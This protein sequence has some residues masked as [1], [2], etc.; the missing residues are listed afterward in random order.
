MTPDGAKVLKRKSGMPVKIG[1]QIGAVEN[2]RHTGFR[3][4]FILSPV[5]G[6]E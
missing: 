5:E 4:E 3:R 6:P 2:E 1:I